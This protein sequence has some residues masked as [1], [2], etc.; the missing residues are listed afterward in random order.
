[1]KE[2]PHCHENSFG[3]RELLVL[4]YFSVNECEACG[5]LVRND[6]FRQLLTLPAILMALFLGIVLF[7]LAPTPL[8]PFGLLLI[9][10]LVLLPVVLLAKPVIAKYPKAEVTPFTPDLENDKM[11]MVKGWNEAE[12]CEILD[13]FEE[14]VS[15]SPRYKIDIHKGH[16]DLHRLTF[17]E[18]IPPSEYASLINYLA[19]PIN[20]GLTGRSII[21]AGKTTLNSDFQGMPDSLVGKKGILYLPENDEDYDVVYLQTETGATLANS[22]GE[23]VWRNV[24]DARLPSEVKMLTW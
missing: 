20:F 9:I 8:Q 4:D 5:Q 17:P 24:S 7:S 15:A 12:L 2:C 10:V 11:I 19:Y 6:G 1:M 23:G 21:V 16:Q 18:D 14:D 22:L 13:D 3:I